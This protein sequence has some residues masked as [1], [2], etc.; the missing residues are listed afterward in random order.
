MIFVVTKTH[1]VMKKN[2]GTADRIVRAIIAI[3]IAALYVT[4]TI[5]GTLGTVLL[6]VA[7]IFLLTSFISFCP[8]YLP[9]GIRTTGKRDQ[10]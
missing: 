9:F 2:M 10:A 5:S 8:L 3:V 1:I 6:V 7:V 4:G